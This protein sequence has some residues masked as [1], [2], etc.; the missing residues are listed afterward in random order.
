MKGCSFV[1]QT[2]M[3]VPL[4]GLCLLSGLDC[5]PTLDCVWGP[6]VTSPPGVS[7][8]MI[9]DATTEIR[10]T[11]P[12]AII[13]W[14]GGHKA[15]SDAMQSPADT[16]TWNFV[17]LL[18][19]ETQVRAWLLTYNGG[20]WTTVEMSSEPVGIEFRDMREV[21]R[22][23]TES[24]DLAVAAGYSPPFKSWEQLKPLNPNVANPLHVFNMPDGGFVIVDTVTGEVNQ[25]R[26]DWACLAGCREVY[27]NCCDDC[28]END[29]D[30]ADCYDACDAARAEC[31]DTCS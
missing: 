9:E 12:E 7:V 27:I 10:K 5:L 1:K 14:A 16:D 6:P 29:L 24:W 26:D 13:I 21:E 8:R 28:R 20:A 18:N 30:N 23:V 4:V 2:V 17:A 31:E 15:G 22:D 19:S 3:L 25:E 11:Q